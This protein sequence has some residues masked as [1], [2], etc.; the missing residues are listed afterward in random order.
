[1]DVIIARC[2]EREVADGGQQQ[3]RG[4]ELAGVAAIGDGAHEEFAQPIGQR[5]DRPDVADHLLAVAERILHLQRDDG[6]VVLRSR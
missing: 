2:A 5:R 6:D 4:H 1:M 3:P